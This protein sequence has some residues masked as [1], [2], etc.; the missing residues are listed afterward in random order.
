MGAV[1]ANV[2]TC[3]AVYE[4]VALGKPLIE[5]VVTVSGEGVARPCNVLAPIGTKASDLYAFAGGLRDEVYKL[6]SGGP[7]MGFAFS[8]EETPITK[9]GGGLLA[10]EPGRPAKTYPCVS[11]SKCVQHCP[12]GLM[13]NRM[14]RLI[15]HD[16]VDEALAIGLMDCK[17]C[18]CCAYS[19]PSGIPLVQ[20]FKLGKKM[21]RSKK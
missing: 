11:C 3:F 5:R 10:L 9:G 4:A 19:C 21:A 7:M 12:M 2:S 14:Y 6:V 17:E 8:D 1:V 15:T 18:G 20:G 16:S 13:P